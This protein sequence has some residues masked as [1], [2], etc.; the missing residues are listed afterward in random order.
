MATGYEV[1]MY[2]DI[3]RIARSLES[4][5]KSLENIAAST[6][7]VDRDIDPDRSGD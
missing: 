3:G 1:K 7:M 6:G 5:A 2:H 4:I